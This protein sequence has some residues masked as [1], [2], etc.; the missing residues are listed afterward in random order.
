MVATKNGTANQGYIRV[1]DDMKF[2]FPLEMKV[3]YRSNLIDVVQNTAAITHRV[4]A[5]ASYTFAPNLRL[6]GEYACLYTEDQD[7]NT[8]V[9]NYIA[10]ESKYFTQGDYVQPFYAGVEIPTFGI[11]S[12]LM[13]EME[14]IKDREEKIHFAKDNKMDDLAWTVALVKNIGKSKLQF[15]VYSEDE[16]SDV[17]LAFRLTS[18]IK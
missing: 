7:I 5:Y 4:A 17:G 3:A 11:L 12:N 9:E 8:A 18:T 10:P 1:E 16:V 6:Y 14:Y 2:T 13:F 15:S